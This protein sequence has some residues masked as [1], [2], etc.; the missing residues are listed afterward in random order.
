MEKLRTQLRAQ[1]L[2]TRPRAAG[3]SLPGRY[4]GIPQLVQEDDSV[5]AQGDLPGAGDCPSPNQPHVADGAVVFPAPGGPMKRMLWPPAQATSRARFAACCPC[6]SRTSTAYCAASLRTCTASTRTVSTRR[7]HSVAGTL[8]G[9]QGLVGTR[10][11]RSPL[12]SM[13]EPGTPSSVYIIWLR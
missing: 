6:T 12:K 10:P 8:E 9:A 5:V 3:A 2:R 11:F 1:W 7:I 4:A 13:R